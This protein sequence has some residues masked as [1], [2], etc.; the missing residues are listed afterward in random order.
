[1]SKIRD[2]LQRLGWQ[3]HD[4]IS[5]S[6]Q[7]KANI[8]FDQVESLRILSLNLNLHVT[9]FPS[10]FCERSRW[11]LHRVLQLFQH[12]IVKDEDWAKFKKKIGTLFKRWATDVRGHGHET[13]ITY[14]AFKTKLREGTRNL[15]EYMNVPLSRPFIFHTTQQPCWWIIGS[16]LLP[17]HTRNFRCFYSHPSES[18]MPQGRE[19]IRR[20]WTEFVT[21]LLWTNQRTRST[22]I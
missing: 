3:S 13:E 20:L 18:C 21:S 4:N 19:V 9:Y 22:R 7:E 1:M 12:G 17:E 2:E 6:I 5:V 15:N 11:V 14:W 10:G 16:F 8:P